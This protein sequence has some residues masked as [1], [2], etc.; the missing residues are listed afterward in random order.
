MLDARERATGAARMFRFAGDREL[1][2]AIREAT[3]DR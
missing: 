3:G 1:T 2:A